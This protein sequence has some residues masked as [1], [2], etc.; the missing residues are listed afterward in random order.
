MAHCTPEM[1]EC[2]LETLATGGWGRGFIHYGKSTITITITEYHNHNQYLHHAT[3]DFLQTTPV[4]S[5]NAEDVRT[6]FHV[7]DARCG[8]Q[9]I[10]MGLLSH[11][12]LPGGRLVVM[13]HQM[14]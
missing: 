6:M 5:T 9:S 3:S 10:K 2:R 14:V 1:R 8:S 12:S 4:E 13:Q 11:P 7:R